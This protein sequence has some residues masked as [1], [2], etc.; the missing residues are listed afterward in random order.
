MEKKKQRKRSKGDIGFDIFVAIVMIIMVLICIYPFIWQSS[1]PSTRDW[2]HSE[3]GFIC[4]REYLHSKIMQSC[5]V[6]DSGDRHL[7]LPWH[8][9]CLELS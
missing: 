3:A 1:C 2:M 6:M 7:R 9:R 4:C 5:S 8:V